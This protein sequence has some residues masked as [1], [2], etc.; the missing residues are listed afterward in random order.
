MVLTYSTYDYS[1]ESS[2][3][4]W[5]KTKTEEMVTA[6]KVTEKRD[7]VTSFSSPFFYFIKQL[8]LVL[9]GTFRNDFEFFE[10]SWRYSEF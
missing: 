1:I 5:N 9:I 6:I 8:L 7:S 4:D 10:H 2:G 3:N